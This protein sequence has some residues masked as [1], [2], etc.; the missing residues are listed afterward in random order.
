MFSK[1]FNT[2]KVLRGDLET[3]PIYYGYFQ[4][5]SEFSEDEYIDYLNLQRTSNGTYRIKK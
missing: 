5:R 1:I 4:N 2:H 3:L